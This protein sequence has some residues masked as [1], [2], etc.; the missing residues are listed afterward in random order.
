MEGTAQVRVIFE[1]DS[2]VIGL[3]ESPDAIA[4]MLGTRSLAGNYMIFPEVSGHCEILHLNIIHFT[5]GEDDRR[6]LQDSFTY[7]LRRVLNI[8]GGDLNMANEFLNFSIAK[9][10]PTS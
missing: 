8:Y 1:T 4:A 10:S 2:E 7:Q 5:G 6:E 3:S 9:V